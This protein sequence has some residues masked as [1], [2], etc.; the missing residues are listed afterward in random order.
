MTDTPF[1]DNEFDTRAVRLGQVRTIENEHSEPIYPTSSY[2]FE[3]AAAAAA[4]FAGDLKGNIYS[5]F[6][7]PGVHSFEKRLA[8]LEGGASCVAT[9]SGM[10]AILSMVMSLLQA[11]DHV[12]VSR[13]V[14]GSTIS[15]FDNYLVKFGLEVSYVS[16][17]DISGWEAEIRPNTR[18]FFAETPSNPLMEICDIAQLAGLAHQHDILLAVDN[19]FCTPALQRPLEHGADLVIHSATKYLDGQ[20]RCIGGAVVGDATQAGEKIYGFLRTAGPTMSPFNA[21][22]FNRGLETLSLRMKA[23]SEGAN[24]LAHWLRKR[25]GV[26]QVHYPGLESHPQYTIAHKQQASGGGVVSFEVTGHRQQAWKII[27]NLRI[28]SVTANLGDVKTTITH[29]ATTTHG[30]MK[31]EQR[32]AAGITEGLL[33]IAVGLEDIDDLIEDIDQAMKA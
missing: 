30:R 22:I 24:K 33:R 18:L 27:D 12:I 14:F 23:H 9:S 6:T 5:R 1:K 8:S 25:E 16:L 3:N 31:P 11:G 26:E 15:L 2:I 28:I 19:C 17:P 13:S 20:G 29:P 10:A 7:N 32:E 21:W 4:I